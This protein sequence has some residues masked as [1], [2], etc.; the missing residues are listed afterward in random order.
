MK[1]ELRK[2]ALEEIKNKKENIKRTGIPIIYQGERKEF[3]AYKIP[4]NLLIYNKL[5]GRIGSS[6]KSFESQYRELD[7]ENEADAKKIEEFLWQSKEDRNENTMD[8]LVKN[9]QQIH[10][11]VTNDGVIIDGNRR[12][13]LLNRIYRNRKK[14]EDESHNVD[15][16]QFFIAIILPEGAD[17][18]EVMCLETT[19]Q[20]GEDKKLDYNAIEKY[21]KCKDLKAVGFNNSDIATMMGES[22]SQIKEW[23]EIMKLMDEYLELLN[24]QGIY[25]RLEKREGQFVDFTKYLSRYENKSAM[26]SWPYDETDITDLKSIGFDYIR[27]QYE[28]KEFRV[29]AQPS[30]KDSFFC[31]EKVWN[32]FRNRHFEYTKNVTEESPEEFRDKNPDADLSKIFRGRDEKWTDQIKNKLKGNLGMSR[33]MLENINEANEPMALLRR[34]KDTL[35]SINTEN[36]AFYDDK[37]VAAILKEINSLIWNY[38]Q[39]IK[40]NDRD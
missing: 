36:E 21:L 26:V 9:G 30:K 4:L 11:I 40:H 6:V 32:D 20:M 23:S 14:W 27:A 17:P 22:E 2:K 3:S 38:Q 15:E 8:S 12:A 18:K 5:N 37:D 16:C 24:Y 7:P 39:K 10:G 1:K 35:E 13:M 34:A 19:Y 33:Q 31:N 29:I 25:T 28:G